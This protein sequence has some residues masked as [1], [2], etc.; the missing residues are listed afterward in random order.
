MLSR[1][2]NLMQLVA[3][4]KTYKKRTDS[5]TQDIIESVA[6]GADE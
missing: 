5:E 2:K 1:A 3:T 4:A 6:I